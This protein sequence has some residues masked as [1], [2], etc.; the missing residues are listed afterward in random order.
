[1]HDD[2]ML[3]LQEALRKAIE[4]EIEGQYF[5]GMAALSTQDGKG[6]EVFEWLAAEEFHHAEFLKAQLRSV[7]ERGKVDSTLTLGNP[8]RLADPYPI[9]SEE[10]KARTNDA[11]FEMTA[12]S[13]GVQ[14]EENA[15]KFYKAQAIGAADQ[16]IQKFFLELADWETGHYSALLRQQELLRDSYWT[17]NRF[18]PF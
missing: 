3:K 12:L 7:T 10:I 1:M 4:A 18:S 16:T 14:L 11:H 2:A 8:R 13:I 15:I 9:F 6:K 17:E 5:Y